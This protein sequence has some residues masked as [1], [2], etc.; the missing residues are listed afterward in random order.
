MLER[1]KARDKSYDGRFLT[2]VLSTGI[3]CLPSCRAR[4]P[5][6][7]NVVHF[8]T[9]EDAKAA[10]LRACRRCRPDDFYRDHDP[11][12]ERVRELVREVR[13][14][15]GDFRD[16]GDLGRSTALGSTKLTALCREHFHDT[17]AALLL[18]A[19]VDRACHELLE[20]RR[21]VLDIAL[22]V[23]FES[24]S[25]FH[26]NFRR[27]TGLAP[28]D[29]R[30][31]GQ[32]T[33]FTLS[34]PKDYRAD[35]TLR[36]LGRDPD[37]VCEQRR[38][39]RVS[40]A[41]AIGRTSGVLEIELAN[42]SAR[43]AFHP[44]RGATPD[45]GPCAHAVTR[46]LLNLASDPSGFEHRV[47]RKLGLGR[48]TRGRR[49]LRVP[50]TADRFEALTWSIVGQQVNLSFAFALRRR[51]IRLCGKK[52]G[53]LF[54]HPPAARV[55]ELE[56]ADLR[57]LQF[58]G[59]KAEYLIG[60]ARQIADG[61]LPLEELDAP[62]A[63]LRRR[64]LSVR[65]LGPWSVEYLLMRAFGL[66]DCVP[67]GDVGLITALWRFFDLAERPDADET[68]RLL[69][70]FAPWRSLASFHFWQ[71]LTDTADAK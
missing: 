41:L 55:A 65:G 38:G 28:G 57:R 20:T 7:E 46:R 48:L 18:Q 3:Y 30:R 1:A 67:V 63:D 50:L 69:A 23:G 44:Q 35:V 64:L 66:A 10:G 12:R 56:P 47:L 2:G 27:L 32:R 29:Y 5:K 49:G 59:R 16:R 71:T 26:D 24:S 4:T 9:I 54:A 60:A 70:P 33:A 14:R 19:R 13:A 11:D 39:R 17:P 31:L 58:S 61:S 62:A 25:A 34:L 37:G 68:R 42:G 43:C 21:R 53:N 52:I 8:A 36:Y 51:L 22:D 6:D 40:K 45:D 15:P